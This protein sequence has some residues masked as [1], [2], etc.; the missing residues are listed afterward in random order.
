MSIYDL[1]TNGLRRSW[2]V[3]DNLGG[4]GTEKHVRCTNEYERPLTK[5]ATLKRIDRGHLEGLVNLVICIRVLLFS[6]VSI[7][8]S[9]VSFICIVS[10]FR[11]GHLVV[12]AASGWYK[13][14]LK[15]PVRKVS[16][17]EGILYED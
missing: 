9:A 11:T 5:K 14:P 7:K 16:T 13:I 3:R 1:K 10:L 12:L 8:Q 4:V 6:L 15:W 17:A 2:C